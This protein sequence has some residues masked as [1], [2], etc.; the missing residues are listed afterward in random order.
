MNPKVSVLTP[1]YNTNPQYLRECIESVL[2][3]TFKDFEFLILNDSPNNKE[4]EKIVKEYAKHDKRIKYI[5][6]AKNIGI[7][8]SR[9]KLLKMAKGEY[10]AIFDHDDISLPERLEKEVEY[11][12][13]NP[14]V[15]VV[16]CNTEWF[17]KKYITNHPVDN[18]EIKKALTHVNIVAHT[19]MM[20]RKSVL[21]K[22]NI[23]YEEEFSPAEDY[24]LCLRLVEYT[25]FHNIPEI[26]LK[27]RFQENNTTNRLWDKMVNADAMCRCYAIAK[28]P[29]L[30]ELSCQKEHNQVTNYNKWIKI[31]DFVPFIKIKYRQHKTKYVLFGLITLFTTKV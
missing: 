3:Q 6:N 5:K 12:D 27:Y 7:T 15:G 14:D 28:Y 18:L 17:P 16:S 21:Q 29:Y 23:E 26:L 11:L 8:P 2:N 20:V 24:M 25:M 10:I 30:Y 4:I 22:Y 13:N 9:N 1:I 31:F 19:A